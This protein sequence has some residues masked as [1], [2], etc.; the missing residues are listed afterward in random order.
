M[1]TD[2]KDTI[3]LPQTNFEMRANLPINEPKIDQYWQ[4]IKLF[5]LLRQKAKQT[6][7]E[8]FI[9][10]DGPPY[11]NGHL[12]IGHALNKILKDIVSRT[13]QSLGFDAVYIP[14]WDCHGLPIEWK[15][16]EEYRAQGKNKDE[17]PIN[18]F[19]AQCREYANKWLDIQ[20]GEF[21]RLGVLGD[22]EN[23]YT[24]MNF[25][26]ESVIAREI[27]KFLMNGGLYR[28]SKP[29]M[30]SIIEKTALAEAE[31]EYKD[32]SSTCI[33]VGFPIKSGKFQGHDVV[34]W[35][36]TPWTIPG[37]RAVAY[38]AEIIYGL[39]E[40]AELGESKLPQDRKFII[41]NS[42]AEEF[43]QLT[44]IAK[45]QK[46]QNIDQ[47][48]LENMQLSHPLA[49][50]H[51]YYQFS[52]PLIMGD[53]VTE[54]TGSGFVHMAPGHGEDDYHLGLKIGLEIPQTIQDDG[55]YYAHVGLMEGA[56]ILDE[57]GQEANA[58]GMVIKH[59][60]NANQLYGKHRI[61]H[62]YPH[63]WRSKAP[64]IF[65]NT[66]QWFISM[67][68]NNL[69]QV[70][71]D[72]INATEFFPK[73]GKNRLYDMIENR[74]DWCISRQRSWGVPLPL[75]VHKASGQLLKDEAVQN[76]IYD[77]FA[78]HG[79]DVWFS[80]PASEFLG[81]QY[82]SED[83]EQIK[84]VV[85]VWF[86]S[87]S[88]HAF[89]LEQREYMRW[90]ADI[91][92]EGSDQHRGWFHSSLLVGCGT[93]GR[94]PY[95]QLLT[96]G[97]VLDEQGRKM[98]KSLGNITT[99][100]EVIEK[101]GADILRLWVVASD[102]SMDLGIGPNALKQVA[103]SYRRIRNTLR[104]ALGM[105]T[106]TLVKKI[107]L[108]DMPMLEQYILHRI[109]KIDGQIREAC[110]NYDFH[111]MFRLILEFC[112]KDLS[113][114]YFDIRKDSLYCDPLNAH[115]RMA[116]AQILHEIFGF[117]VRW[118]AP[119]TC[120]T[121]EEAQM[122]YCRKTSTTHHSIHCE[123]FLNAPQHWV[124]ESLDAQFQEIIKIRKDALLVLE[125]SRQAKEIGS[126]LEAQLTLS[127]PPEQMQYTK[128]HNADIDFAEIII[129]SAVEITQGDYAITMNKADGEKCA[130]CW[131]IEP[132]LSHTHLCERCE[133]AV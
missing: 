59:L 20:R 78:K 120:F 81:A 84:D 39:Y 30:W 108:K 33:F 103:E 11:A 82:K 126:S 9:L 119:I 51:E 4:E 15:I 7:R 95:N 17:V 132:V 121:A 87:G 21:K 6:K 97:F 16:E 112:D 100:Q 31:V 94:A 8:K 80:K 76:R 92:L 38:G 66:P 113:G 129:V 55:S 74:P 62:S 102:Y 111:K 91:Y 71:L 85:D 25:F 26:A 117:L 46:I 22:W 107:P 32:I 2:L 122:E 50:M 96:H 101:F 5:Q 118:C 116:S 70:A 53:F 109:A 41:A 56:K 106:P 79:A 24:T 64:L 34:I 104:W 43:Q 99:P 29:V 18:E 125:K 130:R 124:N 28:G 114:L 49:Q 12:H 123:D 10:H 47:K 75:F 89:V 133:S 44:K 23:P 77:E 19:R 88:T 110:M 3:F 58:N 131:K 73:S 48:D 54:D 60:V 36:T 69:R 115:K 37:N 13:R 42:R 27:G 83:Y 68:K 45:I 86:D 65:R 35:T 72:A 127:L 61:K 1:T 93:R 105:I 63:S 67:D 98:S 128:F 57:K 14:G 40:I 52:V 90:P